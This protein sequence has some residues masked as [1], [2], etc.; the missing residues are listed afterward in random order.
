MKLYIDSFHPFVATGSDGEERTENIPVPKSM[1]DFVEQ[2]M[3]ANSGQCAI[4]FLD[5]TY[6]YSEGG[7]VV[8]AAFAVCVY[9]FVVCVCFA[10]TYG[11]YIFHTFHFMFTGHGENVPS[12]PTQTW[13]RPHGF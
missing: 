13:P 8:S 4:P 11:C 1:R 2:M 6:E 3:K 9:V 7:T 5:S 10:F 12:V